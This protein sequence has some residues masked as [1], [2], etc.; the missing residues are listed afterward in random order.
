MNI[1]MNLF[2]N[3]K[4]L[5]KRFSSTLIPWNIQNNIKQPQIVKA[6]NSFIFTKNKKKKNSEEH[7]KRWI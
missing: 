7:G 6:N 3:K 1:F 4:M 2:K 5:S